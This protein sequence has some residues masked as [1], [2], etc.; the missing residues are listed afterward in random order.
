MAQSYPTEVGQRTRNQLI[1]EMPKAQVSGILIMAHVSQDTINASVVNEFG[2]SLMDFSYN[3]LK[4]RVKLHSV[5][6]AL[7]KWYIRRTL[8]S[9]LR[10]LLNIMRE[11]GTEY[12]D[13]RH[14]IRY[15]IQ[16][17]DETEELPLQD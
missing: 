7:D 8:R 15:L 14:K 6:K 3:T 9:D 2:I 12:Y 13:K 4:D 5:M 11:G 16:P 1:I 10:N 17:Y